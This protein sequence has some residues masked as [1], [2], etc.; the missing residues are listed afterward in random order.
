MLYSYTT[1]ISAARCQN[2]GKWFIAMFD[3]NFGNSI[4]DKRN[5]INQCQ[6]YL[7]FT[8]FESSLDKIFMIW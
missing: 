6:E 1:M 3:Y 7:I 4:T 2:I 5:D 8:E